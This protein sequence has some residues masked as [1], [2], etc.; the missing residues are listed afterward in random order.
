[1]TDRKLSSRFPTYRKHKHTGQAVVTLNGKDFYLG[2]HGSPASRE[3]YAALI[4][5]WLERGQ[6]PPTMMAGGTTG[7]SSSC[8]PTVS[9]L[10]LAYVRHCTAY[11]KRLAAN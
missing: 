1:M 5:E 4:A 2:K 9:E 11:Y 3:R 10:I 7:S 8:P 6:R